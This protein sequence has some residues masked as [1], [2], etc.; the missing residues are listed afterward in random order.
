MCQF[1]FPELTLPPLGL[2]EQLCGESQQRVGCD[3]VPEYPT[4]ILWDG[5]VS[6]GP[7]QQASQR[8]RLLP[9]GSPCRC[10][11]SGTEAPK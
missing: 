5:S 7:G 9:W 3:R 6:T 8:D 10:S 11:P 2:R 1:K 4:R